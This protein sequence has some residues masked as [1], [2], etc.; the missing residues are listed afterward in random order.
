VK[1]IHLG[2]V[3]QSPIRKGGSAT[4]ALTESVSLAQ[5]AEKLGYERYWV[6]E[7]HNSGG[8]AGTAP[9]I[10][11]GQIA[12]KTTT[13]KVGSGGV[14]LSHYSAFKVAEVFRL[15]DAF[16]PERIEIGIGRAPGSDQLTAAAL[17]YPKYPMDIQQFPQQVVDLI[18]HLSETLDKE[19]PFINIKVQPGEAPS[20]IPDIWLLGSS[21]YSARLAAELGLPFS[22]ADFFGST[23][24]HGPQIANLYRK[25]FKPSGY[26][27]KPQLSVALNVMCAETEEKAE[28]IT[29]SRNISRINSIRG[30]REPMI[31]PEEATKIILTPSEIL[32]LEQVNSNQILG[33][34]EIVKEKIIDSARKY[35]T[36]NINIVSNCYYF[37]DRIASYTLVAEAFND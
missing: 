6:A 25:M 26:L 10:L 15:L 18:G 11:I 2:V 34:K 31:S 29:S 3:D 14:M 7:H 22:F 30:I 17:S 36:D 12:S 1:N 35:E 9:E 5:I 23:A 27:S 33:T 8:Y 19:H 24:G 37:E 21:D 13:I 20:K 4:Q 32:H 28:F 16:Y